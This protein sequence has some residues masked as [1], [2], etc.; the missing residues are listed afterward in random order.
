[1]SAGEGDFAQESDAMIT[2]RNNNGNN[3]PIWWKQ[4]ERRKPLIMCGEEP[5]PG[6]LK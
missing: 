6:I 5:G 1:L 2:T 3:D 4:N